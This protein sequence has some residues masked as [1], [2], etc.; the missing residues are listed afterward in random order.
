MQSFSF[1][2]V[3]HYFECEGGKVVG[4]GYEQ[5][6]N[7]FGTNSDIACD[8]MENMKNKNLRKIPKIVF[9]YAIFTRRQPDR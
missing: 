1:F 9:L 3:Y 4:N 2:D 6:T 7:F 5:N 8:A